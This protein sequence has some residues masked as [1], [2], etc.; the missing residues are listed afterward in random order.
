MP[1]GGQKGVRLGGW[2]P[3]FSG[4]R[5]GPEIC[6][7]YHCFQYLYVTRETRRILGKLVPHKKKCVIGTIL[8]TTAI[9]NL[10]D[11]TAV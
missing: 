6:H 7:L 8:Y 5:L 3:S 10:D 9:D 2:R 4:S 11:V 1:S